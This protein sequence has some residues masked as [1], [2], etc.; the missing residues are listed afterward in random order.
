MVAPDAGGEGRRLLI[1]GIN[2]EPEQTGIA[3]FT[4]DLAEHMATRDWRVTVVTGLPNYPQWRVFD[5]YRGTLR[6]RERRADV[7]I[8]RLWH[9]VRPSSRP[10][11]G[12]CMKPRSSRTRWW[13]AG[14]DTPIALLR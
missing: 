13:S 9:Y 12:R 5:E 8:H 1:V 4:T 3:P 2:Y 11:D 14:P 6:R 10:S 7:D